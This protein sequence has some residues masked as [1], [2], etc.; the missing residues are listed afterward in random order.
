MTKNKNERKNAVQQSDD[1][2]TGRSASS[3]SESSNPSK[4]AKLSKTTSNTTT[5]QFSMPESGK[6]IV[7]QSSSYLRSNEKTISEG[8]INSL[9]GK[10]SVVLENLDAAKIMTSLSEINQNVSNEGKLHN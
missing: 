5:D 2:N 8:G 4:R 7:F 10:K 6:E 9:V 1:E 3:S